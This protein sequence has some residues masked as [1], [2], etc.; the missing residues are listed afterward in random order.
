MSD[1]PNIVVPA[2]QL[3]PDVLENLALALYAIAKDLRA[4]K[5]TYFDGGVG[6]YVQP[7]KQPLVEFSGNIRFTA[8]PTDFGP[9]VIDEKSTFN[10]IKQR[11]PRRRKTK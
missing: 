2:T 7:G 8:L 4:G 3:S 10:P 9:V 11:K 1:T 6:I 5:R